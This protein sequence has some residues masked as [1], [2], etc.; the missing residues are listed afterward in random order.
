MRIKPYNED[1][2]DQIT[3]KWLFQLLHKTN[4]HVQVIYL[5]L[6]SCFSVGT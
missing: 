2:Y 3:Q 4:S 1:I 5:C 6:A